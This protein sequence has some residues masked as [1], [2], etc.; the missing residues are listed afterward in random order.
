MLAGTDLLG[1]RV[2]TVSRCQRKR[3]CLVCRNRNGTNNRS[4]TIRRNVSLVLDL[5]IGIS[6]RCNA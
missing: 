6:L 5:I 3:V 2:H 1:N 4:V